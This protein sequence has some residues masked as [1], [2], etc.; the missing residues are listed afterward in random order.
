MKFLQ[1]NKTFLALLIP[2]LAIP[3]ITLGDFHLL[4][5]NFSHDRLETLGFALEMN[6]YAM[7]AL[8]I[9]LGV[10]LTL[11]SALSLSRF[12]CGTLCPNTFFAH[13]LSIFKGKKTSFFSKV[14]GFSLLTFLASTLAFSVVAYGISTNELFDAIAHLTFAGWLVS[15]LSV[16]MIAEVYMVQGWYCAYLCP[17]GAITAIFPIEDRLTYRFDD[18]QENCTE[19]GG[20]VKICPIPDL[21]I[22][23]GFDIRCIQCGLCEAACEKVFAK[24][25]RPSLIYPEKRSILRA[26]GRSIGILIAIIV[27]IIFTAVGVS[28]LIDEDRLESCR[29][30]NQNLHIKK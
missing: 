26:G 25:T 18:P 12:Y 14:I 23:H 16:L 2:F 8:L 3:W 5:F 13:L 21:D 28:T 1:D 17:Y 22:R 30:E 15:I 7:I 24:C 20:C 11:I 19:C 10:A 9:L 6:T 29:L 27:I 4:L